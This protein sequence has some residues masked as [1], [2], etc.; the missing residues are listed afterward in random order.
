MILNIYE[1][2][3]SFLRNTLHLA[4]YC[5]MFD[6]IRI[7]AFLCLWVSTAFAVKKTRLRVESSEKKSLRRFSRRRTLEGK[8]SLLEGTS[9]YQ[10]CVVTAGKLT[11][12]RE[13]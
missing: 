6:E 9:R 5:N 2:I 13:V 8:T 10:R 12:R 4:R 7:Q 11:R 1:G 3:P